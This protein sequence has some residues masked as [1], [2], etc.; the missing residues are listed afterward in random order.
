MWWGG[1]KDGKKVMEWRRWHTYRMAWVVTI[2]HVSQLCCMTADCDGH[3]IADM[4]D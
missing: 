2:V 4:E 1:Q 3:S